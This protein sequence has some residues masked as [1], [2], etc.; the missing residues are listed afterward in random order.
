MSEILELSEGLGS[1]AAVNSHFGLIVDIAVGLIFLLFALWHAKRGFYKTVSGLIAL[2]VA[3]ALGIAG[4]NFLTE[5][6]MDKIW[7]KVEQ[8]VS[9]NYDSSVG[10]TI[11]EVHDVIGHN[12]E[13][14]L[15][16]TK[17]HG[18]AEEILKQHEATSWT[19][20]P[21]AKLLDLVHT[22]LHEVVHAVLFLVIAIIGL[23]LF[24]PINALME[25]INDAPVLRS[26]NWLGG[27]LVG[28][29]ECLAIFF[30]V[31]KIC[32]LR[33]VSFF[34][35]IQEGSWFITKLLGL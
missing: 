3:I 1:N 16:F 15:E 17:L 7:P 13:M 10:R 8:T 24:K 25:K 32:E 6:A 9:D 19:E 21:K 2:V 34:R 31:I 5:P 11:T 18:E 14:L 4:A 20:A 27:F 33:N 22:A 23:V 30:I 12:A 35:D 26:L 28:L 29:L